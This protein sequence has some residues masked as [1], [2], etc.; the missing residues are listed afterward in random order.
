[1]IFTEFLDELLENE[2]G[3]DLTYNSLPTMYFYGDFSD[4]DSYIY[5]DGIQDAYMDDQFAFDY[6]SNNDSYGKEWLLRYGLFLCMFN[7]LYIKSIILIE[8]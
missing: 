4:N 6:I 7:F 5:E 2:Y 3:S 1:M 8:F